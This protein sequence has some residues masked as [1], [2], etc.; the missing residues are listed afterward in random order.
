MIE[1]CNY[2]IARN[3]QKE[4]SPNKTDTF[5]DNYLISIATPLTLLNHVGPITF[6]SRQIELDK[7][8][9]A[10]SDYFS[11]FT[12]KDHLFWGRSI[13]SEIVSTKILNSIYEEGLS[14]NKMQFNLVPTEFDRSSHPFENPYQKGADICLTKK[15][16]H[17]NVS[18]LLPICGIDVTIG[19]SDIIK[20]KRQKPG[21]QAKAA[22]PIIIL[23]LK[24]LHYQGQKLSFNNYLDNK[25]R[26]SV[27]ISGEYQSLYGLTG[28]DRRSWKR[29]LSRSIIEASKICR[30]KISL[31][32]DRIKDFPYFPHVNRRLDFMEEFVKNM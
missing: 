4:F 19:G 8:Q 22:I 23:P 7:R 11:R 27:S 15:V 6:R 5:V 13:F 26:E 18:Y 28:Q 16:V 32:D 24:D 9:E 20:K 17:H 30:E 3:L 21:L 1:R 31:D 14:K 10:L 2:P 29:R 12:S 25:A